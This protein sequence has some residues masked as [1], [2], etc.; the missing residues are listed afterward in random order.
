MPSTKFYIINGLT[1]YRAMA[2]PVILFFIVREQYETFR[3]LLLLSFFTDAIDGFLARSFKVTTIAGAKLDSVAD[4][5]TILAA[6]VGLIVFKKEFLNSQLETIIILL[7]LFSGQTIMSIV[8]YGKIS[9]FHTYLAK[10]AAILQALS[11]LQIFFFAEPNLIL[12][13]TAG[14]ITAIELIEEIAI[15][16]ILPDWQ[17][18]VK[19][20]YWV[21]KSRGN[22][23]N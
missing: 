14:G 19:G 20:L 18:N 11:I 8:R 5:L 10:T 17:A 23:R 3:W 1:L 15:V 9:S 12:F 22:K 16:S 13:Y 2:A 7:A 4:D 21:L 6:I